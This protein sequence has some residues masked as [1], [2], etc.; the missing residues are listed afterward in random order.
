MEE[1]AAYESKFAIDGGSGAASEVPGLRTVMRDGGV[2]VLQ[3]CDGN[4]F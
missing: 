1:R 4:Y 2:G 3:V